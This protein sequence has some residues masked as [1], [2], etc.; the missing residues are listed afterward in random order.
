MLIVKITIS[1]IYVQRFDSQFK[2]DVEVKMRVVKW[3]LIRGS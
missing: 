2:N 1:L 3:K